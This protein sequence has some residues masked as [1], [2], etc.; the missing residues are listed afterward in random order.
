MFEVFSASSLQPA[1]TKESRAKG[2]AKRRL[3]TRL[4]TGIGGPVGR[5]PAEHDGESVPL[6]GE[7]SMSTDR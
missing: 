3:R 4:A 1:T 2:T 5:V 7:I 6:H